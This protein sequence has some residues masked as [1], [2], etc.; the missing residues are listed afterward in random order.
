MVID[1]KILDQIFT[2]QMQ[3]C[4]RRID[5]GVTV[6]AEEPQWR[7]CILHSGWRVERWCEEWLVAATHCYIE[8]LE[9]ELV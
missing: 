5:I 2:N 7:L 4:I 8:A 3:Y 9:Q 6:G 1:V